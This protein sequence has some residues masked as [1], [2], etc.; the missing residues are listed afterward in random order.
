M[1]ISTAYKQAAMN[2]EEAIAAY[3]AAIADL[4][5]AARKARTLMT[6]HL[7]DE[8]AVR[9]CERIQKRV[10]ELSAHKTMQ[11]DCEVLAEILV[12]LADEER[13]A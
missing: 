7:E 5:A 6:A 10:M 3:E 12:N 8:D 11:G 1:K 4:S 2:V 13:A 9:A